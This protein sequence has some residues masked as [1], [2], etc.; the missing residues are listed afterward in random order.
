V[1]DQP[2]RLVLD[3]SSVLAY[4]VGSIDVGETIAEIED[5]R[6][7]VAIPV[8]C[9]IEAYRGAADRDRLEVLATHSTTVLVDIGPP[10]WRRVAQLA[11]YSGR[12]DAAAAALIAVDEGATM[13][14]RQAAL[15]VGMP[16]T[17]SIIEF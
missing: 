11:D 3:T 2:I 4:C 12:V 5:E 6:C 17:F 8:V 14:T 7:A 10:A 16:V 13:L 15:Y 9:L 1:T